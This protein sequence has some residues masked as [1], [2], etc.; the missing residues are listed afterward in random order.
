MKSFVTTGYDFICLM[1]IFC[2]NYPD[3]TN[4]FGSVGRPGS[5]KLSIGKGGGPTHG[6]VTCLRNSMLS[7]VYQANIVHILDHPSK[8]KDS[9]A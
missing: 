2:K 4:E 5:T 8:R 9:D 7:Y 6:G 1:A 3:S